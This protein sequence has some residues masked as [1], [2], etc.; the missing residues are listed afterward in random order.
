MLM[1][2]LGIDGQL[3]TLFLHSNHRASKSQKL[4]SKIKRWVLS[5]LLPSQIMLGN[6]DDHNKLKMKLSKVGTFIFKVFMII[7]AHPAPR[8]LW[9]HQLVSKLHYYRPSHLSRQDFKCPQVI[10]GLE[11]TVVVVAITT[12]RVFFFPC[13]TETQKNQILP[14]DHPAT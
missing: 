2:K 6:K 13:W 8:I 4:H 12:F 7:N 14:K 9:K 5:L 11:G 3:W 10:S 1:P